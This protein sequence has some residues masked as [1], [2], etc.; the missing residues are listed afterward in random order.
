MKTQLLV[1]G[2]L[3]LAT[4]LGQVAA[5]QSV[6]PDSTK[7]QSTTW[8]GERAFE[9]T[10]SRW[11]AIVSVERGR[12]VHFGPA[13][14]GATNLLFET[15]SRSDPFSWG[16][17]RVWLGPQSLWGWPPPDAWERAA[18]EQVVLADG[19]LELFMPDAGDGY[20]RMTRIY[21]PDGDRLACRIAVS[22]GT[23]SVQVMQILQTPAA[24][25][26]KLR[27]VPTENWPRGYFRVGGD[28]GPLMA[29]DL[30]LPE[31]ITPLEGD[32][33]RM[34]YFGRSDKLAFAPQTIV[35]S[36]P[37]G[38]LSLAFGESHGE[39]AA[40]PDDGYYTQV[41]VGHPGAPV[42]EIEQFS[43][44][45]VAGAEAE[46]SMYIDLTAED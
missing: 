39:V 15:A 14:L 4:C 35:A 38:T 23:R 3:A 26:T 21:E 25:T 5:A 44:Q 42:V 17:H 9:L 22:G 12:L 29:P 32:G 41:Y 20:P 34:A 31:S 37:T 24:T 27:P 10:T 7:W 1:L 40:A 13:R 28:E 11:R 30:P 8:H 43:P 46:F 6:S 45:W 16:G 2:C 36:T 18:A 19:R 33:V